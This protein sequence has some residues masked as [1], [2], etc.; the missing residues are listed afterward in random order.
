M[1][2]E[3]VPTSL[4]TAQCCPVL[5]SLFSA[6]RP[7]AAEAVGISTGPAQLIHVDETMAQWRDLDP[8]GKP[9]ARK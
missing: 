7:T 6:H 2:R 5:L 4:A 9:A 8:H 3:A 1:P